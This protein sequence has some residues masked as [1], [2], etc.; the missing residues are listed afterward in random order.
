MPNI[1]AVLPTKHLYVTE[2]KGHYGTKV[3]TLFSFLSP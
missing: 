2:V 3:I 1:H